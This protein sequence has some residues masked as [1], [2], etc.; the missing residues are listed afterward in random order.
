MKKL[1]FL[2]FSFSACTGN[3]QVNLPELT[4]LQ[5]QQDLDYLVNKIDKQFAGFTTESRIQFKTEASKIREAIPQL[6]V[7]QRILEFARLLALL[8]DGHTEIS[9]VGPR[10][11]F[12][13]F[14]LLLYYFG[15][16]LRVVG[17]S[18]RY[19]NLLGNRVVKIDNQ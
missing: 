9:L 16:E 2:L 7:N 14:P 10:S 8:N 18:H 17:A 6:S 4:S 3:S 19:K 15:N 11:N 13:R 12:T 5:W 1:A